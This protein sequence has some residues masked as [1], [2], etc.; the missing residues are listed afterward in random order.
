MS[1]VQ[2]GILFTSQPNLEIDAYPHQAVHARVTEDIQLADRLGYDVA[3]LAEHHFSNTYGIMPDVMTY[4]AY[5]AGQTD[6]IMLGAGVVVMP[7]NNPVRVTENASFIDVLSGG[8]VI[9]GLGSGYRDYEYAGMG[10]EFETRREH[11]EEAL[12]VLMDLFYDKRTDRSGNFVQAHVTEPHEMFPH[13]VQTPHPPLYMAVASEFSM[14]LCARY[15]MGAM[16]SSIPRRET[17]AAQANK[18]RGMEDRLESRYAGNKSRGEFV[19]N[20]FVHVAETDEQARQES[21]DGVIRHLQHFLGQGDY[22]NMVQHS[23]KNVEASFGY[24]ALVGD[25]ILHGSPDSVAGMIE[26]LQQETGMTGLILHYPPYYGTDAIRRSLTLFAEEVMPRF[27][28]TAEAVA[29]E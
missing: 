20:R 8:R 1:N 9:L 17:L 15:G 21:E 28:G 2:F 14:G 11:Q 7:L 29:A 4:A 24:D 13:P 12:E 27:R 25:I 5:L 23:G 16:V 22:V 6:R 26:D 19:V 18:F 3:W 10:V